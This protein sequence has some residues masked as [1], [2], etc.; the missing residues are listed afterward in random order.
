MNFEIEYSQRMLVSAVLLNGAPT[1]QPDP[2][3]YTLIDPV[4]LVGA[5][6]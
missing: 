3:V 1:A 6:H 2:K 4:S 5:S